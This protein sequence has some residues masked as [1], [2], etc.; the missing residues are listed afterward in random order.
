MKVG[1]DKF[2][3][4]NDYRRDVGELKELA[5]SIE[6]IGLLH[7]I[8]VDKNFNILEGRRR[9]RAMRDYL[10]WKELEEGVNFIFNKKATIDTPESLLIQWEENIQ[11]QNFTPKEAAQLISD[12]HHKLKSENP[13]WGQKDTAAQIHKSAS[14]VSQM[15]FLAENADMIKGGQ[16][17]QETLRTLHREKTRSLM[18]KLRKMQT[19]EVSP[20]VV[21][22]AGKMA[23]FEKSYMLEGDIE[24]GSIDLIYTEP[25][26]EKIM[27]AASEWWRVAAD[28]SFIILWVKFQDAAMATSILEGVGFRMSKVPFVWVKT[29]APQTG[30]ITEFAIWGRKGKIEPIKNITSNVL[31]YPMSHS[32]KSE[33]LHK[34]ILSTFI[35]PPQKVLDSF[36]GSGSAVR[37]C[38]DLG[39][40]VVGFSSDGDKY[41]DGISR[42]YNYY[43]VKGVR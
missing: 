23:R 43:A 13:K 1:I 32:E 33:A 21:T 11:R 28:N 9:F 16:T 8:H 20:T 12:M 19:K 35:F 14:Y 30:N 29:N 7:P 42:A 25:P 41:I 40:E 36:A 5:D 4:Y 2:T 17:I 10:G 18:G 24:D 26:K 31:S 15:L 38:I 6:N 3:I 39:I 34:H 27:A 37:A 22:D